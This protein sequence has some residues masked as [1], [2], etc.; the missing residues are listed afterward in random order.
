M[1][2]KLKVLK[3]E[4]EPFE[5]LKDEKVSKKTY[6]IDFNKEF[7][8]ELTISNPLIKEAYST[9]RNY[10]DNFSLERFVN[11]QY[12]EYRYNNEPILK[13]T[14][15]DRALR[16][17][18][19]VDID[20]KTKKYFLVDYKS[21]SGFEETKSMLKVNSPKRIKDALN[22][23]KVL[24]KDKETIEQKEFDYVSLFT[25]H[26]KDLYKG[27]IREIDENTQLDILSLDRMEKCTIL[28]KALK[29][30][31]RRVR[32]MIS[33]GEISAAFSSDYL[34]DIDLLKEVG[35]IPKSSTF[36]Y[37]TNG[38]ICHKSINVRA[39]EYDIEALK[40]LIL[41]GSNA[42]RII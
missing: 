3:F 15:F 7:S 5:E 37:I 24:L 36:L 6:R 28:E 33:I 17:Y 10:L 27:K 25:K 12:E 9:I 26:S 8:N 34:I 32:A 35:L 41:S 13:I 18:L 11:S 42:I 31:D 14:L 23:L 21:F 30:P 39:N 29:E 16:L 20:E 38:G 19:N 1:S 4:I 2:D 40:M 22:L